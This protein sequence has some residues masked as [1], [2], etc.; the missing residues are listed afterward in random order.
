VRGNLYYSLIVLYFSF[1]AHPFCLCLAMIAW[2][3]MWEHLWIQ[4]SMLMR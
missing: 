4:V 2:L 1:S 3:V